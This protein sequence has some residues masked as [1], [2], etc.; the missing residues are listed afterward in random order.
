M[1]TAAPA[2]AL[3]LPTLAIALVAALRT[4]AAEADAAAAAVLPPALLLTVPSTAFVVSVP[5]A[6]P[7]AVLT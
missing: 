1:L 4:E 5:V 2:E 7:P 6:G 3:P